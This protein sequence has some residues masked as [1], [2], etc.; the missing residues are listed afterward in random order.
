MIHLKLTFLLLSFNTVASSLLRSASQEHRN[1]VT[2]EEVLSDITK[3]IKK[4]F[5]GNCDK[6]YRTFDTTQDGSLSEVE[7]AHLASRL[8]V[9]LL[10]ANAGNTEYEPITAAKLYEQCKDRA[11]S[12]ECFCPTST[13]TAPVPVPVPTPVPEPPVG[14]G[15]VGGTYLTFELK[16]K[17]LLDLSGL[18]FNMTSICP[19]STFHYLVWK[20]L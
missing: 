3:L 1:L 8:S 9:F 18:I 11:C 6:F 5:G 10:V 7:V 15:V 12:K 20:S 13:P 19:R 14:G 17:H 16:Y 4:Q 2:E